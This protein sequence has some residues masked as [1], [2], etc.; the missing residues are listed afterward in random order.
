MQLVSYLA[1]GLVLIGLVGAVLAGLA[2]VSLA[3]L[4]LSLGLL[5]LLMHIV[6][7]RKGC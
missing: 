3:G 4:G 7:R 2:A 6:R 5:H 1:G